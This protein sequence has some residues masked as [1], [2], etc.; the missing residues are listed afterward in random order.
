MKTILF[1]LAVVLISSISFSQTKIGYEYN[2]E[3]KFD[4]AQFSDEEPQKTVRKF[5]DYLFEAQNEKFN[6]QTRY[7]EKGVIYLSSMNKINECRVDEFFQ[8]E[9]SRLLS[10]EEKLKESEI[11]E[12]NISFVQD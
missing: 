12:S 3:I 1:T 6:V 7:N 8:S 5:I 11:K 10:F 4:V 9:K 2:Y